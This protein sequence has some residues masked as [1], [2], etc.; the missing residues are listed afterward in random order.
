MLQNGAYVPIKFESVPMD[1]GKAD[2]DELDFWLC[3]FVVVRFYCF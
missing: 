1:V 3:K 2:D